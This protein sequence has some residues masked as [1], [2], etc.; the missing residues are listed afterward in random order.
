MTDHAR[1]DMVRQA[2]AAFSGGDLEAFLSVFTDGAVLIEAESLPYGGRTIGRAAIGATLT[3]V[4]SAWA[5]LAFDIER[6]LSDGDVVLAL[7]RLTGTA[8]ETGRSL[9]VALVEVWRF[10][11]DRA[12]S[13]EAIYSD[14]HQALAAL[15]C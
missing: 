12:S 6:I 13:V 9:D 11:G 15:G 7:G 5:D 2:Y 14:T 10:D 4:G 8:R 3:A 1:L